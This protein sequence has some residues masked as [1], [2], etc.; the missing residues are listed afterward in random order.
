MTASLPPSL[1]WAQAVG[2]MTSA[3]LSGGV[4]AVS[5]GFV[6]SMS[7]AP[8]TLLVR[9]WKTTYGRGV[10]ASPAL[11]I[12]STFSFAYL[13]YSLSFT[14]NHHKAEIFALAAIAT[15]SIVPYTLI[16]MK[17]VNGK[18]YKKVKDSKHLDRSEEIDESKDKKGE[19]SRDLL[20]R[21]AFLNF[22]RGLLPF[23][24]AS[25]GIYA[26]FYMTS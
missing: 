1:R 26:S 17:G 16:F 25:L 21:W 8:T 23:A 4:L 12:V 15:G 6:P 9:E 19:R 20:D 13:S 3:F 5:Y 10:A 7:Q 22:V 14:L 24:G 18:L 2:I 11:A